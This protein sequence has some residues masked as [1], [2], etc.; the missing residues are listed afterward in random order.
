MKNMPPPQMRTYT[1]VRPTA[2][3]GACMSTDI[4]RAKGTIT[5]KSTAEM[6]ANTTADPPITEPICSGRFSPRY[7]ATST[8]I[9]IASCATAKVTR[10]S[11]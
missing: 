5:R 8:V 2:S 6:A 9:P 1:A 10:L 7:R 4:G 11:T 3:A